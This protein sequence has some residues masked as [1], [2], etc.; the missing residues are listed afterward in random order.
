M[1][2]VKKEQVPASQR[3][4]GKRPELRVV[5]EGAEPEPERVLP[6]PPPHLSE[7]AREEWARVGTL[8]LERGSISGELDVAALALYCSAWA[9]WVETEIAIARTGVVVRN[10]SQTIP[11]PLLSIANTAARQV[12]RMM[13]VLGM[14]E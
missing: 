12:E 2:P 13:F 1:S 11:S 9:R 4:L 8:L 14:R 5:P 6:E 7:L 10:G 3:L